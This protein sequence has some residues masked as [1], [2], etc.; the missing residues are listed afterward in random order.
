MLLGPAGGVL[1]ATVLGIPFHGLVDDG[2]RGLGGGIL[3]GAVQE[4]LGEVALD[5]GVLPRLVLAQVAVGQAGC[6]RVAI[7]RA[8]V[9]AGF[10]DGREALA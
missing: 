6:S 3:L 7:I 9:G 10:W 1:P 5:W 8:E 4:G 2:V